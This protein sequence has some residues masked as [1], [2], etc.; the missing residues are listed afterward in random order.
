LANKHVIIGLP[1]SSLEY[2]D[3]LQKSNSFRGN[4]SWPGNATV[5]FFINKVY[6]G[7]SLKSNRIGEKTN[8]RYQ[9]KFM[10]S[11]PHVLERSSPV[12]ISKWCFQTSGKRKSAILIP[13]LKQTFSKIQLMAT[14]VCYA[15]GIV[16]SYRNDTITGSEISYYC[17]SEI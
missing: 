14:L 4:H 10:F 12:N 16:L 13:L 11:Q 1:I 5:K 3:D 2:S 8:H 6:N 7:G 9:V 17:N 15:G